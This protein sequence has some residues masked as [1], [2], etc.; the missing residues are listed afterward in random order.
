M[1]TDV[2]PRLILI[3]KEHPDAD[4]LSE[5]IKKRVKEYQRMRKEN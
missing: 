4:V 3:P 2:M 5:N 1:M